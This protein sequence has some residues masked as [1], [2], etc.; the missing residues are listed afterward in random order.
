MGRMVPL[1]IWGP[2]G[3]T[4]ELGTEHAVEGLLQ[5]LKWDF[6]SRNGNTDVRGLQVEVNEFD[7]RAV[8]QVIYEENG[9]TIRSH[10]AIHAIDGPVG[11][12][13]EWNG[14][15]F[16]FSSDTYPNKWFTEAAKGADLAIHECF[17]TPELLMK[18]MGFDAANALNVGTQLHTSAAQFGKVMSIIEP[19]MAVAYHF[20][21]DFDIR[22]FVGEAVRQTYDGPLSFA[23]DYMVWNIT[24]V[25]I[26]TRMAVIHE[27]IWPAPRV[28][29]MEPPDRSKWL[30]YSDFTKGGAMVFEDVD[31]GMYDYINEKYGTDVKRVWGQQ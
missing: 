8:N 6:A 11:F 31:Q 27:D 28:L 25:E 19:R 26:R 12:T 7:Y 14:L 29:P 2:S 15:K 10:P 3:P 21:T 16:A 18:Y 4:P 17:F 13:L 24:K 30:G 5:F 20:F 23:E 22:P 1:R 9:V